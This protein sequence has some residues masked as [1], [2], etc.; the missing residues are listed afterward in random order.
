MTQI[1]IATKWKFVVEFEEQEMG[2]IS[3]TIGQA[4]TREECEA[5]VEYDM[6]YHT[7]YGRT[8]V[9]VEAAEICTECEGEGQIPIGNGGRVICQ[10]CGGHLGPVSKMLIRL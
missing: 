5:L 10:A 9:N 7:D 8:I 3:G 1:A 4:D 2:E 6:Q